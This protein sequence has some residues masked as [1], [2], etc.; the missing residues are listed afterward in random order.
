VVLAWRGRASPPGTFAISVAASGIVYILSF[1][2][3]GVA[4]EF[5]YAYWCVLASLAGLIPALLARRDP[6]TQLPGGA[7]ADAPGAK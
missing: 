5:R 7:P 1:G 6:P 4:A 3:F 2:V